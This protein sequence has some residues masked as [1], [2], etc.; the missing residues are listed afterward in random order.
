MAY[1]IDFTASNYAG[2]SRRKAF[3]RL[4]LL[5]L[6]AGAGWGVYD[7]YTTYN[8]PT[9]NMKLTEFEA[10]SRPIEEM[11]RAWD[12]AAKEYTAMLRY[13]RL[14]WAANPVAFLSAAANESAPHLSR[15]FRPLS[16]TLKTG[17]ACSLDW[18]YV[19]TAG[20]KAEQAK[21]LEAQ[22]VNA[23]TSS[24][25]VVDAKVDVTG[26]QQE[27][28]LRVNELKLTAKFAL[29]DAR[30][31][32]E[33]EKSLVGCVSEIN[34]FRK[35]V[36]EAKI[37]EKADAKDAV[38]T[39]RDL[40]IKYLP[41]GKD[42]PD[43][44][45]M[46][47]V[48]N[49]GGWLDRA[50]QFIVRN[51][52]PGDDA[53]R[54]ALKGLWSAIGDARYPWDRFRALDNDDLVAL[55]KALEPTSDG[56]KRFKGFLDQRHEF[57]LKKLEPFIAG[58]LR[59]DVFNKP[60]VESDLKD[61][62]AKAAGITRARTSFKELPA[63]EPLVLT[64]E[65]ETFTFTWVQWTLALGESLGREDVRAL[66]EEEQVQ[67]EPLTLARLADCARRVQ[68]LGP[69]YAIET[70]RVQFDPDGQVTGAVLEGLLPVKKVETKK[71]TTAHVK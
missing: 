16:W 19:F 5:G 64:K 27:N 25:A 36:Q 69:G 7:V 57:C 70:V 66:Q 17:G 49:V 14:L 41:L 38:R 63:A 31:F 13:Y 35:K 11:N 28:L 34:A 8:L 18:L 20:D 67:A 24:V 60:L 48:V 40:M 52:I 26:V 56:V 4:M 53:E 30:A 9:L 58:Y 22:L 55:T 32:P 68:E 21:G 43:F 46:T 59:N 47:N 50:D 54:R 6:I 2:R 44:P 51:R 39:P 29:P 23:V 42:K 15:G 62:V 65:D 71:E 61:R 37:N 33:K 10:V 12:L 1:Q 3:L 45:V